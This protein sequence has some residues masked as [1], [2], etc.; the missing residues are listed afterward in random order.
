MW[1][2]SVP[3]AGKRRGGVKKAENFADVINVRSLR[4]KIL[5]V[6]RL[7]TAFRNLA[8]A[9]KDFIIPFAVIAAIIAAAANPAGAQQ[10]CEVPGEC[11]GQLLG[12]DDEDDPVRYGNRTAQHAE[13]ELDG[14]CLLPCLCTYP[15]FNQMLEHKLLLGPSSSRAGRA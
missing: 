14:W 10:Q 15:L 13:I 5:R 12:F 4:Y 3:N 8:S 1:Y 9:M 6:W 7:A 11:F 2:K